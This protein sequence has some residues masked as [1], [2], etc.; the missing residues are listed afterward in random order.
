MVQVL[1]WIT[2]HLSCCHKIIRKERFIEEIERTRAKQY[3]QVL[4]VGKR[5]TLG[6]PMG[7]SV[8]AQDPRTPLEAQC[9][10]SHF[11]SPAPGWDGP[12]CHALLHA[13]L[14]PMGKKPPELQ[15]LREC[16]T[17]GKDGRDQ[18]PGSISQTRLRYLFQ[19]HF[20]SIYMFRKI[21]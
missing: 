19:L 16:L 9:L 4:L 3:K 12:G 6:V 20:I 8:P 18:G 7:L 10:V 14:N 2:P 17:P 5:L 11:S 21:P 1:D 15:I 13:I